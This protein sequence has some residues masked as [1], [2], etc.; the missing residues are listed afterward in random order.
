[1]K[2]FPEIMRTLVIGDPD[3]EERRWVIHC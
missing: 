2:C 3:R 1:L